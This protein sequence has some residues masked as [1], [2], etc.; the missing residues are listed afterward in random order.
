MP[1]GGPQAYLDYIAANVR[2]LRLRL[3]L[4]QDELAARTRFDP[5]M[6]QRI[7]RAKL[8]LKMSTFVRL[9]EAL[10]VSPSALLRRARLAPP[11]PGRPPT[12]RKR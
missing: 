11:R 3:G 10:G 8:D 5:R 9:A 7:E 12:R 1:G 6:F 4:T 2:R